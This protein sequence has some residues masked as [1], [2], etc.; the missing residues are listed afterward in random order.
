VWVCLL[1][2]LVDQGSATFLL[3]A[4]CI[5]AG[6]AGAIQSTRP[7]LVC[8]GVVKEPPWL[9]GPQEKPA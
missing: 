9:S 5:G 7:D 4:H 3:V 1:E 6:V 8:A 2:A